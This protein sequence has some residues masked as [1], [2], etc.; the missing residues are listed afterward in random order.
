MPKIISN[1]TELAQLPK[2]ETDNAIVIENSSRM[3]RLH[4]IP[5]EAKIIKRS[6]KFEKQYRLYCPRCSLLIAYETTPNLKGGPYT[7]ITQGSLSE[8]QGVPHND[9][10]MDLPGNPRSIE[11]G[12]E[13]ANDH[14]GEMKRRMEGNQDAAA[15]ARAL[16]AASRVS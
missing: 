6:D 3:Y 16:L 8:V 4:A 13:D 9:W 5:G 10:E 2:R 7:Y 15:Q 1:N 11:Q 12:E 14:H